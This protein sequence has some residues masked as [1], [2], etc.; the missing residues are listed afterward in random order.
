MKILLLQP[1]IPNEAMWG[2]FYRGKGFVPPIGLLSIAGY[3]S[4]KGYDVSICD[5]QLKRFSHHDLEKFLSDNNFNI[6]GI[7]V[8]TNS[9]VYSFNTANICRKILPKSKIIFGGVH[10]TIMPGQVLEDCQSVDVVV[11]GEGEYILGEL[12]NAFINNRPID[13]IQSIAYRGANDQ[14]I[15]NKRCEPIKDLD[16][17]PLP[18][19]NLID[20]SQ[21]IPHPTQYK[22]LP[23]F[24]VIVQR[25]CPF[26]CSFCSA[27]L[28]HGREVRFRSVNYV[29]EELKLLKY[30]YEARGIYF[31]DS[32]FT[33]NKDYCRELFNEM[34]EQ[35]LN[36]AWACNTR[37][38]CVNDDLLKLMKRAGCWAIGYGVESC[39]QKSLDL[40]NKGITIAQIESAIALTHK[41]GI[42]C[43]TS[44]ILAIP[45]EDYNDSLKTIK[46]AKKLAGQIALFYPPVPYPCTDLEAICKK[47]GGFRSTTNWADYTAINFSNPIYVNPKIGQSNMQKLLEFAYHSYYLTPM[48]LWNNL[49]VINSLDDL[50]RY[51][52]A[53][54]A[55]WEI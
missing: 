32:T 18:A 28:V 9:V 5:S 51:Y 37:V 16:N 52:S 2:K 13:D 7:P 36:L 14:I 1:F 50:K 22:R 44:F 23:N 55:V 53:A 29:L 41:N 42:N 49:T 43:L 15:I 26:N 35:R 17:L 45:G 27:H 54:R 12:I 33:L 4:Y 6:I 34:I 40:L 38:D 47:D 21:Y 10:A 24:P 30:S 19:Y 3:L 48:V 46:F 11:M 25:G 39:N 20:M 8:F 31:Q